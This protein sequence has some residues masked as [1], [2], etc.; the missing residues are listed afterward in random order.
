MKKDAAAVLGAVRARAG[1][2]HREHAGARVAELEVLV[3]ELLAVDGLAARAVAPREVACVG[4]YRRE[5]S[6]GHG[7]DVEATRPRE[8]AIAA[9][10][11]VADRPGA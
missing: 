7:D 2:G 8:G 3:G 4:S 10:R 11:C 1:V 9:R 6:L 5:I